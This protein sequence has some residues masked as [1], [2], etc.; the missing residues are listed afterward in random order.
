MLCWGLT[1][2]KRAKD[3]AAVF[4][5]EAFPGKLQELSL[6]LFDA[7]IADIGLHRLAGML[8]TAL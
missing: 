3:E 6:D 2:D 7:S 8:V 5:A 4:T 1:D